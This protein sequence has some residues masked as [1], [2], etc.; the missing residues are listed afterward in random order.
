MIPKL[1]TFQIVVLPVNLPLSTRRVDEGY[2][3]M[4]SRCGR[5]GEAPLQSN[6][7]PDGLSVGG[8][9]ASALGGKWSVTILNPRNPSPGRVPLET[10]RL[11]A[12]PPPPEFQKE[13]GVPPSPRAVG[14]PPGKR[15]VSP[16]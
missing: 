10:G 8:G 3:C 12:R 5:G 9:G 13:A 7:Q 4:M 2:D 14:P 6:F 11:S 16:R 1:G 15:N